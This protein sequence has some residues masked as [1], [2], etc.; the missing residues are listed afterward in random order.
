MLMVDRNDHAM[1]SR[2]LLAAVALVVG[3][4]LVGCGGGAPE[5]AP[6]P[7][8]AAV[9][10]PVPVP[11]PPPPEPPSPPEPV[12]EQVVL[13]AGTRLALLLNTEVSTDRNT[14]GDTFPI[15]I[16]EPV[17]V[18]GRVVLQ[19]RTPAVGRIVA[20]ERPGRVSGVASISLV[21]HSI[22]L[23]EGLSP[24]PV[25]LETEP[26]VFSGEATKGEDATKVGVGAGIGALI[27]GL[28]G[29][30]DGAATGAAIGAGAGAAVVMTTRGQDLVLPPEM[31]LEFLVTR[32]VPLFEVVRSGQP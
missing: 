8:P 24:G 18:G 11:T 26:V 6:E 14:V 21:L 15:E 3:G 29:G 16:V 10:V 4:V 5:S 25:L 12:Y 19:E 22:T 30:S 7:E 13:P 23:D 9:E 27:G 1:G 2:A 31:K 28:F 32:E 17:V 20:L